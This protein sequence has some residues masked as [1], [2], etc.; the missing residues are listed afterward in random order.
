MQ[1]REERWTTAI[2]QLTAD[3]PVLRAAEAPLEHTSEANPKTKQRKTP[4]MLD[5]R[6]CDY[7]CVSNSAIRSHF[8]RSK[9]ALFAS[10]STIM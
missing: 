1:A 6:E 9:R 2:V 8:T 4:R 5:A 7:D 10:E 3:E